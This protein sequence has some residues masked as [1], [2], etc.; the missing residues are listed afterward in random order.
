MKAV[1]KNVNKCLWEPTPWAMGVE[2]ALELA[3]QAITD[4]GGFYK[5]NGCRADQLGG[6]SNFTESYP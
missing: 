3:L 2:H 1:Q 5:K 4:W 6:N